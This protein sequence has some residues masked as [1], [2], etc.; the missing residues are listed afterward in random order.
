[1]RTWDSKPTS[2]A[3]FKAA[4]WL[5]AALSL[6]GALPGAQRTARIHLFIPECS[7]ADPS[8]VAQAIREADGLLQ[9]AC[10]LRLSLTAQTVLPQSQALCHLP[11]SPAERRQAL[12]VLAPQLPRQHP[13][14]LALLLLLLPDGADPRLC[15]TLIDRSP[16]AGCGSPAEARFLSRFGVLAFS[17]GAWASA[18]PSPAL[19][20]LHEALHALTQRGHPTGEARGNA[21]ADHL[22]DIGPELTEDEGRCARSSPYLVDLP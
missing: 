21:L 2:A 13:T 22:A 15:W 6:A 18:T 8:R 16:R 11:A 17:D 20:L 5:V 7:Q 3:A 14:D 19:L 4:A 10:G 9:A 12:A 1:L